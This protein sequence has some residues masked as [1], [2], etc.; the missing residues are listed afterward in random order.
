MAN[1][2]VVGTIY[3]EL[4][5]P[6]CHSL[7]EKRSPLRKLQEAVRQRFSASVAEVDFQDL[8][9]RAALGIAICSG[10]Y[11]ILEEELEKIRQ[12]IENNPHAL[13]TI[14]KISKFSVAET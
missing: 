2:F 9:Q 3:V 13:V 6:D 11:A 12:F 1:N 8:W 10:N 5:F 7:K 14:L 4:H